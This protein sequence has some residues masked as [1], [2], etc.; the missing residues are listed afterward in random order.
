MNDLKEFEYCKYCGKKVRKEAIFCSHCGSQLK[1]V[2]TEIIKK[3]VITPKIKSTAIILAILFS[4]WSWLYTYKKNYLKF[5]G[6]IMVFFGI[7]FF[8]IIYSCSAITETEVS[9][10]SINF[11]YIYLVFYI[12]AWLY[13]LIYYAIK[14]TNFLPTTQRDKELSQTKY[15][16]KLFI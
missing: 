5:W 8:S 6:T 2:Q 4:F 10:S 13:P 12:C 9:M 16:I 11:S 15:I 7:V 3:E 1:V 14:P